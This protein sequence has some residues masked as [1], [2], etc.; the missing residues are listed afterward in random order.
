LQAF[1]SWFNFD[2]ALGSGG[3]GAAAIVSQAWVRSPARSGRKLRP[4]PEAC[5]RLRT[6]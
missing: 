3:G 5:F 6:I 1:Q 2:E 4:A